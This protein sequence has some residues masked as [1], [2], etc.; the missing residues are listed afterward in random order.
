M[1]DDERNRFEHVFRVENINWFKISTSYW[2]KTIIKPSHTRI[3]NEKQSSLHSSKSLQTGNG[4]PET[5]H[6]KR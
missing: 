5:S 4:H 1:N 6:K 3:R 2:D